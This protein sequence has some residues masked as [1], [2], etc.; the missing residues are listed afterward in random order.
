LQRT[1]SLPFTL[2]RR[3]SPAALVFAALVVATIGAFFVTTR[4]KRSAPVIERL[5]F[6][7]RFSPNG[8]GR[9]D[10]VQF[11]LRLRHTDD[12]T[13]SIVTR[14]GGRVRTIVENF[15]I[16][17]TRRYRFRWDGRTESG[18][19]APDGEYHVRIGLRRQGRVVTL[20]RRILLDTIPPRPVV[21]SVK[22]SVFNPGRHAAAA[23]LRYSGPSRRPVLLVYRT[24]RPHPVLVARH[25]GRWGSNVM[26]WDGRVGLGSVRR[27]AP[28]GSY[29]LA[30]RVHDAAGNPGPVALP[31][32]RGSVLGH[33]GVTVRYLGI[34]PPQHPVRAD[35]VTSF[36]VF[37]DGRRYRWSVRRVGS[38]RRTS[39]GK[40]R[41]GMLHVRA[42]R[43]ASGVALLELRSGPHR[44]EMPFAVQAQR[45]RSVLIVLPTIAWQALNPVEGNGDGYPDLLPLDRS[46]GLDRPFAGRGRPAAFATTAALLRYLHASRLRYDV[47]TD[48]ELIRDGRGLLRRYTGV[49]V[50]GSE[51]FASV[52]LTRSLA[53]YVKAGGRLAWVGT[54]GFSRAVAVSR[55]SIAGTRTS[56]FLGER[57]RIERGPRA[58]VVLGDR[59]DFFRGVNG[60]F[61]PFPRLEP[62][63]QLPAGS[64]LLASA[65]AEPRRP[66]VV[67]Y[68]FGEGIV[69][70]IGVD[71]F[72]RSLATSPSAGRIMRRL[73]DLL[74]R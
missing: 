57:V 33:P 4:L 48:L 53:E 1:S 73:W 17:K 21:G 58:L 32:P 71:G 20:G 10:Y 64:R 26:H 74:S 9:L 7:S 18:A 63:L 67:V 50:A 23:T 55:S 19:I 51:R 56:R 24:D 12:A 61:G 47:T 37:A 29:L 40:S 62:S 44:Y 59:I 39:H 14:D 54:R 34:Q 27:L 41:A 72:A 15:T 6:N 13:I 69:A 28:P 35:A 30:V 11:A 36:R 3:S 52:A 46:V 70:R 16:R 43:G 22:P 66:D 45:R 49:L 25:A 65:G 60:A 38:R 42:P 2:R 5:S 8:D 68:R 31:P